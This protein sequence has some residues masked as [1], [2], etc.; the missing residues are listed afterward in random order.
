MGNKKRLLLALI[1][2]VS[3]MSGFL[4]R[5]TPTDA[6]LTVQATV[7]IALIFAWVLLDSRERGYRMS[8]LL[9]ATLICLTVF[10]LPYY[11]FKSRGWRAGSISLAWAWGMFI[12]VMLC[13]RI[14]A[15]L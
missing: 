3:L 1:L 10:A 7:S 9:K 4:D 15:T 11:L 8:W 2:F 5:G 12:A 6:W 14:G 13:Y